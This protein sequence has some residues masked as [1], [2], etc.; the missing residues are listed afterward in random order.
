MTPVRFALCRCLWTDSDFQ[1]AFLQS[2]FYPKCTQLMHLLSLVSLFTFGGIDQSCKL[3]LPGQFCTQT[4]L[5]HPPLLKCVVNPVFVK[6]KIIVQKKVGFL[7]NTEILGAE[8]FICWTLPIAAT[9]SSINFF[10][11]MGGTWCNL[12]G[13]FFGL[14]SRPSLFW[15]VNG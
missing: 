8:F 3:L 12:A 4:A 6:A 11:K 1:S 7:K 15:V 5:L 14:K 10:E 2:A 13:R 9:F